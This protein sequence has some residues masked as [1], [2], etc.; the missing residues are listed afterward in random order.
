[1]PDIP[2]P[3]TTRSLSYWI[4]FRFLFSCVLLVI[5]DIT[6]IKCYHWLR[7]N[8]SILRVGAGALCYKISM[9]TLPIIGNA[10]VLVAVFGNYPPDRTVESRTISLASIVRMI[11]FHS[12]I[13]F[14]INPNRSSMAVLPISRTGCATVVRLGSAK[15]EP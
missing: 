7:P 13:S 2:P 10:P 3:V 11:G 4:C 8:L 1:M 5:M 15:L 9:G 6:G 12:S 14:P